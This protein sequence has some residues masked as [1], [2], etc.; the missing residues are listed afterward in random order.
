MKYFRFYYR[1]YRI[2]NSVLVATIKALR[3]VAQPVPF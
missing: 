1:L 2:R 3:E